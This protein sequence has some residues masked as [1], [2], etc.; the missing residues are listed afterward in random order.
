MR[1]AVLAFSVA[2]MMAF[3]GGF[4]VPSGAS[5]FGR[6]EAVGESVHEAPDAHAAM[7]AAR[8]SGLRYEDL[9]QRS[10]TSQ[11]FAEPNGT[12]T[13]ETT[14][15]PVR[16]KGEDGQW[17]DIDLAL[18]RVEG[19]YAP[20][21]A[22]SDL[23]LSDGGDLTFAT[24]NLDGRSLGWK[25][26]SPLPTPTVEGKTATYHDVV[27][28]GDLVV[29]ATAT[30]FQHN[31][32]LRSAPSETV[33]YD[34]PIVTSGPVV[35]GASDGSLK[36]NTR[37][38][39]ELVSAT[40]PVMYDAETTAAG[41]PS[42]VLPVDSKVT[43]T[44]TGATLTLSPDE[45]FL[46][47]PDTTYPVTID[48]EVSQWTKQDTWVDSG[49]PTTSNV[50]SA[51]L[52][53]GTPDNGAHIYRSYM[54]FW[55]EAWY[56]KAINSANL[57]MA[58]FSTTS[59]TTGEIRAYRIIAPW[60]STIAW[61]NRP[62]ATATDQA[63]Y[64]GGKGGTG[65]AEGWIGWDVTNIVRGWSNGTYP[66]YGLRVGAATETG[67]NTYR[68]F[69]SIEHGT[70]AEPMLVVNYNS[71][72]AVPKTLKVDPVRGS[73]TPSGVPTLS[74]YLEDADG[75]QVTG[76]FRLSNSDG[77]LIWTKSSGPIIG[78]GTASVQV[79]QDLLESGKHYSFT[80]SAS[81]GTLVSAASA[82]A[83][84]AYDG[85]ASVVPASVCGLGCTTVAPVDL[86]APQT[87]LAPGES[88]LVDVEIPS[89]TDS[90]LIDR[91]LM[92]VTAKG[93]AAGGSITVSDPDYASSE[94]PT[95]SYSAGSATTT[96]VEALPSYAENQ[97]KVTNNGASSVALTLS[98][99]GWYGW[100]DEAEQEL[101][102]SQEV[103]ET[104]DAAIDE[105]L[106][107]NDGDQFIASASDDE[108]QRSHAETVASTTDA[109]CPD[110]VNPDAI[111]RVTIANDP[112][113]EVTIDD[114]EAQ[115]AGFTANAVQADAPSNSCPDVPGGQGNVRMHSRWSA[116][117]TDYY[118]VIFVRLVDD[119]PTSAGTT[120]LA[121]QHRMDL[122]RNQTGMTYSE[123][124]YF[125]R[126]SG[127]G[128]N[129]L[130]SDAN[131]CVRVCSQVFPE[132][133]SVS[134]S[135]ASKKSSW[136]GTGF[137]GSSSA[138][139]QDQQVR[140]YLGFSTSVCSEVRP[141]MCSGQ[142]QFDEKGAS[143]RCDRMRYINRGVGCV[144]SDYRPTFVQYITGG[145]APETAEHIQA[146][147]ERPWHMGRR[148]DGKPLTRYYWGGKPNANRREAR[149]LCRSQGITRGCDEYPFAATAEG[150]HFGSP[151]GF[152]PRCSVRKVDPRDNSM[153][154]TLLG[155]FF[156]RARILHGDKFWVRI[157][158]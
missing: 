46:N 121:I 30:G 101:A 52:R 11:V 142:G 157:V 119:V 84:F 106:V 74:A 113:P 32:V 12:W 111:C 38:G 156:A 3:G 63:S 98:A 36:V 71:Y 130:I 28:N 146:V 76:T 51:E 15:E 149:R 139:A 9:S 95:L 134:L 103:D 86:V 137:D 92:T 147:Q 45:A 155:T 100:Y 122:H 23:L 10:E 128:S 6:L 39:D 143:V 72:P 123:R 118:L 70:D 152:P 42:N 16:A 40:A 88:L 62:D 85:A 7:T 140:G 141:T 132:F 37:G 13:A 43:K 73:S 31:I 154:G 2:G 109:P 33:S 47:D 124:F 44:S 97:V 4:L 91:V 150:C 56:G 110:L 49:N 120:N 66:N 25:W 78:G 108:P 87:T 131:R 1:R 127:A 41:A 8:A 35:D 79:P 55:N 125:L 59:C 65:C 99:Y 115:A 102:A 129:I 114:V 153:G 104:T 133:N 112:A 148:A 107:L 27:E 67:T 144:F 17:R 90:G 61:N 68:R 94:P 151:S 14:T 138:L 53:A 48:P 83:S 82:G 96:T 34:I 69:W 29:T 64:V 81:D 80:V 136:M 75:D 19:G 20:S 24:M 77:Q 22:V 21:N 135:S 145:R 89:V 117:Q 93:V 5:S 57:K 60:A 126:G 54:V 18:K 58:N 116:C 26:T 158:Q 50:S 105:D